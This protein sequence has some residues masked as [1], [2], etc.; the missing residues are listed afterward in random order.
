MHLEIGE[1]FR[2]RTT[3]MTKLGRFQ[4]STPLAERLPGYSPTPKLNRP[5]TEKELKTRSGSLRVQRRLD[6]SE[7]NLQKQGE[8]NNRQPNKK[9][10]T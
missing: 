10:T 6:Y 3:N 2:K 5:V 1:E 9:D 8:M 7:K 4:E